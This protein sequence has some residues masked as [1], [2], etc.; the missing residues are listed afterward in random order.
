MSLP[1]SESGTVCLLKARIDGGRDG[2]FVERI[3]VL[4]KDVADYE[5]KSQDSLSPF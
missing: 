1:P 2:T 3:T 4:R 5:Q